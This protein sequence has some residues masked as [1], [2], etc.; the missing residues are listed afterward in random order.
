L[1]HRRQGDGG[2]HGGA[3]VPPDALRREAHDVGRVRARLRFG[4]RPMSVVLYTLDWVPDFPR[5][6][7]RDL[8]VRWTLEETGRPYEVATVPSDPKSDAH[9]AIQPFGQVP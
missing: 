8:R 7:V 1:R 4:Q 5:G 9:R 2:R 3:G 6:F